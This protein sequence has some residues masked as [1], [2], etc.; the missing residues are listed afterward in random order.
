MDGKACR[1]NSMVGY[2]LGGRKESDMTERLHFHFQLLERVSVNAELKFG[3][4]GQRPEVGA[5]AMRVS[6]WFSLMM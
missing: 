2:S 1:L 5:A 3:M 4:R 6:R